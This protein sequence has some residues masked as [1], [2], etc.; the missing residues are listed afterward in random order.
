[1][2]NVNLSMN[3]ILLTF[4]LYGRQTWT[5]QVTGNFSVGG[6]LLLIRKDCVSHMYGLAVYMMEGLPFAQKL[7]LENSMSSYLCFQLALLHSVTYFFFL[8]P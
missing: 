5:T 7:S 6:Y 3:Q 4:L 1:M 8:C 2:L